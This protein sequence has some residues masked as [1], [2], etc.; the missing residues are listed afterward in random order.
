MDNF[1]NY[2]PVAPSGQCGVGPPTGITMKRAS[3]G[4]G[5]IYGAQMT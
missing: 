5:S 1:G 4:V 2:I 3:E